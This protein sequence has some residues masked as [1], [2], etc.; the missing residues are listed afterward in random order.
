MSLSDL[1]PQNALPYLQTTSTLSRTSKLKRKKER[2]GGKY[3][4]SLVNRFSVVT[5]FGRGEADE[6]SS[7]MHEEFS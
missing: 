3:T 5:D 1:Q 2:T 7:K 6:G 4:S